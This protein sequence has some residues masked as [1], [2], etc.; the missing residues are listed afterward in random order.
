MQW[1]EALEEYKIHLSHERQMS[2]HSIEAYLRDVRH[3]RTFFLLKNGTSG[4][5]QENPILFE[6]GHVTA[7]SDPKTSADLI[8]Q[9]L[10]TMESIHRKDMQEFLI[11]VNEL[12]LSAN[13]QS[14]ML[15]GLKSFFKFLHLENFIPTNP[16]ADIQGPALGRKLPEVLDVEEIDAM[17]AAIDLSTA[18]G[19]RNRAM[20]EMLYGSGL[21]VSELAQLKLTNLMP[22]L[23]VLRVIGKR[24]K[25][26]LVPMGS[27]ALKFLNLYVGQVRVHQ[28]IKA[29]QENIVFL[30][31]RGTALTRVMIFLIIKDLAQKAGIKK[32][33]SPHTFRHSF[34]THLLEGGADLRAIQEMLGHESIT[35]TEIYTHLKMQFLH[36]TIAL[37]HP[38]AKQHTQ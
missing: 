34:A 11:Y 6:V 35:T 14:R 18:E 24:N 13:T 2:A 30:S 37:Y 38:R 33:V 22:D 10:P 17:L 26:R 4:I 29:G 12:G 19:M 5:E 1:Q 20:I 21:R 27:E 36:E 32:S 25:E 7:E 9:N 16:V 8:N 31:R 15:S 28:S 23:M 3:L